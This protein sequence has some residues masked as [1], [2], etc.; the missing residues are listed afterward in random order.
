MSCPPKEAERHYSTSGDD[1][2][3]VDPRTT[4]KVATLACWPRGLGPPPVKFMVKLFDAFNSK[5]TKTLPKLAKDTQKRLSI[6]QA[7]VARAPGCVKTGR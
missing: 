1:R 7:N 5:D 4:F 2:Y 3:S 6:A